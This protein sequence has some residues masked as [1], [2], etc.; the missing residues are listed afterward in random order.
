MPRPMKW[1][2][3]C[4]LPGNTEF[5]PIGASVGGVGTVAMTVDEY[6]AIRLIDLEGMTQEEC[7]EQMGIARTTIQ[8]VYD[9]ARRK[10]AESIVDGR[11]LHIGGGEFRLCDGDHENCFRKGCVRARCRGGDGCGPEAGGPGPGRGHG[12]RHGQGRT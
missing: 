4:S 9:G 1:R 2:R 7:A 12:R 11:P 3:V 8:R 6:E 10:I 5:G